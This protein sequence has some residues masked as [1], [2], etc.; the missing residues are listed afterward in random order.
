MSYFNDKYLTLIG[1]VQS[2]KTNEEINYCWESV[3]SKKL[4]VVFVVRNITADQLQLKYRFRP[5]DLKVKSLNEMTI[6]DAIKFMDSIG[7]IILLCNEYQLRKIK[8]VL[9]GYHGDYNLCIDEVDFSIKSKTFETNLDILLSEIKESAS[10]ILGATATPFAL[11]NDLTLSKVRKLE[12]KENY[13]GIE[14]LII[15]YVKPII[16]PDSP[17]ADSE[18]IYTI[19]DSLLKKDKC[20][21]L[22]NVFKRRSFQKKLLY[23]LSDSFPE[24]TILTYNGDGIYL[25]SNNRPNL[26]F[27]KKCSVNM[28]GQMINKYH[29]MGNV[30]LFE[31]YSISEVLQILV[32]DPVYKHTH[33]SIISG[34]LASRGIS[35][36]SSDYSLHLTDQYF[37]AGENSHGENLLQSLR[38]LGCYSD[39]LPL[40]LWCAE[41]TWDLILSHNKIINEIIFDINDSK[42]WLFKLTKFNFTKLKSPYT[43][44]IVNPLF[45][46]LISE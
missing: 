11:F 40:T 23:F 22:H 36:V 14:T 8:N 26:P 39:N 18:T 13:R 32:D 2:G 3:K 46:T 33:I 29:K 35:L 17:E 34:N 19:Y 6:T 42:E 45:T 1:H 10:H 30:H 5:F 37:H 12:S 7:I 25:I 16:E 43:R 41:K 20:F 28:Y 44:P 24:F 21:I 38:I 31:N 15:N 9:K 4:P 27:T